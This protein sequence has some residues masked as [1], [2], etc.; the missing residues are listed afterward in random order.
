MM[1][2]HGK[3]GGERR[4]RSETCKR[5]STTF[6]NDTGSRKVARNARAGE[7]DLPRALLSSQ[8]PGEMMNSHVGGGAV[9]HLMSRVSKRSK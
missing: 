7:K 6:C 3:D 1:R 2:N 4:A 8:K 5:I 9:T